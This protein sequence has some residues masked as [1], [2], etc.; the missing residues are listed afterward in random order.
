MGI[1]NCSYVGSG[2]SCVLVCRM[3]DC[4]ESLNMWAGNMYGSS[5]VYVSSFNKLS[6]NSYWKLS[7]SDTGKGVCLW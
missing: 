3:D 1:V 7:R 5:A 6:C 4:G 2:L